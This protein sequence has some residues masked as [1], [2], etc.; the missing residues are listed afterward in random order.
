MKAVNGFWPL[1][2]GWFLKELISKCEA[3]KVKTN[4]KIPALEARI[5]Y[6]KFN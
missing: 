5:L 4:K 2:F 3:N 6:L 1:A